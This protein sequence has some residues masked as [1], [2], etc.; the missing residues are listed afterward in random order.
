MKKIMILL[1]AILGFLFPEIGFAEENSTPSGIPF[2]TL[3]DLVDEYVDDYIGKT[4]AGTSIVITKDDKILFSKGYGYA[5]IE[6]K[7]KM[8]SKTTILE[9]G[10]ISKLFVWI[11][12]MQLVEQGKINLHED[13]KNYLPRNFLTKLRYDEPITMQHLMN[14]QA[15]FEDYVFDLGYRSKELVPSLEKSL[16]IAEP[17]QIYKPGEVVA[18]SNYSTSLAAYI[19]EQ[20]SG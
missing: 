13:I 16:K 9:W 3:E 4:A 7:I 11:S 6:N 1:V 15:G 14:H 2:S 18:Y 20:V 10:S 8:N 12:V 19:V 5:D 17:S